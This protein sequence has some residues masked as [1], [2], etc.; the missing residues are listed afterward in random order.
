MLGYTVPQ[1][2]IRFYADTQGMR[3]WIQTVGTVLTS[4]LSVLCL[5]S[6]SFICRNM[7]V[8]NCLFLLLSGLSWGKTTWGVTACTY[9]SSIMDD[10]L[11]PW[12]EVLVLAKGKALLGRCRWSWHVCGWWMVGF[13]HMRVCSSFTFLDSSNWW[14][15]TTTRSPRPARK[16]YMKI[17]IR[18]VG[19]REREKKKQ[20]NITNQCRNT[21]ANAP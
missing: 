5:L 9:K 3:D 15:P 12:Q 1:K 18:G 7:A 21:S 20:K 16:T 14:S 4:N 11:S 19:E 17:L 13:P 10:T 6:T 2:W 8:L